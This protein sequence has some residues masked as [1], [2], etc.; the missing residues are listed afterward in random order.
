MKQYEQETKYKKVFKEAMKSD[1]TSI[2]K[3]LK[4]I[5][6]DLKSIG[7]QNNLT[8]KQKKVINTDAELLAELIKVVDEIKESVKNNKRS[9]EEA[10]EDVDW[11]EKIIENIPKTIDELVEAQTNF[12]KW[13]TTDFNWVTEYKNEGLIESGDTIDS[14]NSSMIIICAQINKLK[15]LKTKL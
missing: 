5:F 8:S 13:F 6:F 11:V 4:G 14:I 12:T 3:V 7:E 2:K 10:E 9:F 15:K 1:K